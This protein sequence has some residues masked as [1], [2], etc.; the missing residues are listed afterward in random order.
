MPFDKPIFSGMTSQSTLGLQMP[1][2]DELEAAL[3][4]ANKLIEWMS[5]YIGVMAP[6]DYDRCYRDLNEHGMFMSR[7][8]P[9]TASV[10]A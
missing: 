2:P 3:L 6:G 8:K 5:T 9:P 7:L 4:R 1:S 10:K